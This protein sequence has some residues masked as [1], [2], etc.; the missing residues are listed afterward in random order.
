MKSNGTPVSLPKRRYAKRTPFPSMNCV[1]VVTCVWAMVEPPLGLSAA[2]TNVGRLAALAMPMAP[3]Q[4]TAPQC[5]R[6][7][8]SLLGHDDYSFH[9][10]ERLRSPEYR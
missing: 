4:E 9:R 1:G 7:L 3:N 8:R 2:S 6:R 5:G 10:A